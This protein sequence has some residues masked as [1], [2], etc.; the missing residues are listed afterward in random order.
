MKII[1]EFAIKGNRFDMAIG[2]II[3]TAFSKI[4]ASL[5]DDVV[6]PATLGYCNRQCQL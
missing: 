4:V 6:M 5:V 3:G 2:I 1:K